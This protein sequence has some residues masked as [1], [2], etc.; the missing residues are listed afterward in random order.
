[1]SA[2]PCTEMCSGPLVVT[3]H[4]RSDRNSTLAAL[5]GETEIFQSRVY[6]IVC[7]QGVDSETSST[8]RHNHRHYSYDDLSLSSH[9]VPPMVR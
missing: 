7:W 3:A 2:I 6:V 1:M 8:Q 4:F 5:H 9:G